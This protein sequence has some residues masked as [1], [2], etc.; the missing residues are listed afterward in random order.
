MSLLDP[1][2]K[3]NSAE[4]S[5]KPGYLARKFAKLKREQ[6]ESKKQKEAIVVGTIAPKSVRQLER[7]IK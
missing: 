6:Q 4:E 3:Y 7:K 5:R 1:K 2:W